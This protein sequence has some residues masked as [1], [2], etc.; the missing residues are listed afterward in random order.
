MTP[1]SFSCNAWKT[2]N[3]IGITN[4]PNTVPINI[5][6]TAAVPID[7]LLNAPAP[8]ASINGINPKINAKEV[9]KI[10]LNLD[11]AP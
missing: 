6:P 8:V 7:L 1:K 5:P 10:G 3:K 11:F 2:I 4:T 9:I